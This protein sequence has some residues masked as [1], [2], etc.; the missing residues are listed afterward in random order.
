[1][2]RSVQLKPFQRTQTKRNKVKAKAILGDIEFKAKAIL[3]DVE[4]KAKAILGDVAPHNSSFLSKKRHLLIT[5][6]EPYAQSA[7]CGFEIT[8]GMGSLNTLLL[9]NAA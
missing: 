9:Q 8:S 6:D 4:F 7:I 5:Y 2:L 1:M 3:G